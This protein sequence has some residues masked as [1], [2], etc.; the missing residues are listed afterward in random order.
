MRSRFSLLL[1]LLSSQL[2]FA[3]RS[4][5]LS[6]HVREERTNVPVES[7]ALDVLSSGTRAASPVMSGMDGEF[8]FPYLKDGDYYIVASKRGYDTVTISVSI[9]AGT[10]APVLINLPRHLS[11]IHISLPSSNC[12]SF[13]LW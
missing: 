4:G 3:Q 2:C 10:A 9:I 11:L 12:E 5:N 1:L 7:V 8:Q 6:G 13:P